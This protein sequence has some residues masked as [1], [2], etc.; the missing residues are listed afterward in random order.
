MRPERR[1]GGSSRGSGRGS[2]RPLLASPLRSTSA[3]SPSDW[4]PMRQI[5]GAWGP[6]PHQTRQLP[7]PWLGLVRPVWSPTNSAEDPDIPAQQRSPRSMPGTPAGFMSSAS[8]EAGTVQSVSEWRGFELSSR[9]VAEPVG[10][11]LPRLAPRPWRGG[12]SWCRT[13]RRR[14]RWRPR[15]RSRCSECWR[16][17]A[18]SGVTRTLSTSRSA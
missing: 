2:P 4:S 8:A 5:P 15:C 11:Q 3:R 7:R 17:M 9:S 10:D 14:S 12:C 6:R 18:S 13:T 16:A 1:P